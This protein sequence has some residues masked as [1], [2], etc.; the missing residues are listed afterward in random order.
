MVRPN[1]MA[2]APIKLRI[3]RKVMGIYGSVSPQVGWHLDSHQSELREGLAD[4]VYLNFIPLRTAAAISA[5][6]QKRTF[7]VH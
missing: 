5:L 4:T 3:R 7:A 6:G 1:F 2:E